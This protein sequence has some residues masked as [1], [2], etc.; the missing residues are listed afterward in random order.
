ME[1][2]VLNAYIREDAGKEASKRMR[3]E[4]AVPAVVYKKGK[5]TLP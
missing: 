1:K 5:K 2:V 4:D 3:S